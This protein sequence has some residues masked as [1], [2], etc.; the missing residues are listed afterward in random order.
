MAIGYY[1]NTLS[2]IS[3]LKYR[4]NQLSKSKIYIYFHTLIAFWSQTVIIGI[5]CMFD[6]GFLYSTFN[7][8]RYFGFRLSVMTFMLLKYIFLTTYV[9]I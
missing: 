8:I 6:I 7:V 3:G 2:V 9:C 1:I 5:A 4:F